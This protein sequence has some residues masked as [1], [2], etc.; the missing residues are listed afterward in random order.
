M[1]LDLASRRDDEGG[2]T[3]IELLVV[4]IIVGILA[5]IAIPV[6]L[7]QREKGWRGT[8]QS[9]LRNHAIVMETRL[10]DAGTYAGAPAPAAS[11]DVTLTVP[12]ANATTYC[13]QAYH[14]NKTDEVWSM[15]PGANSLQKAA[16]SARTS[17]TTTA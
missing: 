10:T 16:C 1:N 5:A 11:S 2:F 17:A 6:F 15:A 9:D 13:I 12:T 4:V 14:A 3:L 8:V 7:N